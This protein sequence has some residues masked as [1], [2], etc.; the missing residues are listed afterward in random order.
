MRNQ[1]VFAAAPLA[2]GIVAALTLLPT[3]SP[4]AT[5]RPAPATQPIAQSADGSVLLHSRAATVHGKMLRYEPQPNKNTLGFW[6]KV[7]DWASWDFD[8]ARAGRYRVVILQGCGKGSGG[9][10]VDF[11]LAGQSLKV[12]VQDTGHFQNFVPR[13]IGTIDL[14][15]GRHTLEVRPRTKPGV[16]VMDLRSV[17]LEPAPK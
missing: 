10:D 1:F 4:A 17:T 12:T 6:T 9:A 13:D 8:L 7:E 11:L 15:A 2:L 3:R 5:T 14:P 16:A